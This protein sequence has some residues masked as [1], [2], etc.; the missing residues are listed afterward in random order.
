MLADVELS[1]IRVF[2]ALVE[3]LHFGRAAARLAITP[4]YVSQTIRTLE[5]RI[6]GRLFDRTSRRVALT[7]LGNEL[8][9]RV[10]PAYQTFTRALA[11]TRDLAEGVGG[12]L[13][14]GFTATTD[15][16][17][18]NRLTQLFQ[19]RHPRCRIEMCEIDHWDPYCT[20]RAGTIDVLVNWLAV[21]EPDLTEG[22]TLAHHGRLLAVARAHRLADA[23]SV[24]LNQLANEQ[25]ARPPSSFPARLCDA[26]L[27][28]RT[29]SGQPIARTK[30]VRSIHEI[31]AHVARGSIVHITV[32]GISVVR[33]EDIVLIPIHD[34]PAIPLGLIW[35]RNRESAK[36]RA[37]AATARTI[38]RGTEP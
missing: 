21:D 12:L 36:I 11:E 23:K 17:Q 19:S 24:S 2:L 20:L 30:P 5:A 33:R 13:R 9:A 15:S 37:L 26:L 27:P 32:A 16:P 18:V 3:D 25:V 29:A 22:P 34:L 31:L 7:P 38:T 1:Q 6:G 10:A 4:S 8:N 14:I 28:P 35:H